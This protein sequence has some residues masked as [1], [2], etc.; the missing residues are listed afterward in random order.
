MQQ[1]T[2]PHAP[3][4][5]QSEDARIEL[6][7]RAGM[8]RWAYYTPLGAA[9]R[10]VQGVIDAL[11]ECGAVYVFEGGNF[12]WPVL[13]HPHHRLAPRLQSASTS[14]TLRNCMGARVEM[15]R[16]WPLGT[17]SHSRHRTQSSAS[18]H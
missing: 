15:S 1:L 4:A 7:T 14:L 17:T 16:V 2:R 6:Q 11:E 8:E 13:P 10:S 9:L 3:R 18:S 12:I 5:L